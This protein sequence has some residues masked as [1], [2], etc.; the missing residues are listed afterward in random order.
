MSTDRDALRDTLRLAI[1]EGLSA[2]LAE[3]ANIAD[4]VL[5]ALSEHASDAMRFLVAQTKECETCEGTGE[6]APIREWGK[7]CSACHGSGSVPV[8]SPLELV[9]MVLAL[10]ERCDVGPCEVID[11][12]SPRPCDDEG[13]VPVVSRTALLELLRSVGMNPI[14]V[15]EPSEGATTP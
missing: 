14:P 10:R 1:Y 6:F 11:C 5:D 2:A 13:T 8:V 3:S 12:P 15:P 4:H 9:K 7:R